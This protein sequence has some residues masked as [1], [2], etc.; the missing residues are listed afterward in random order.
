MFRLNHVL[1]SALIA[2]FAVCTGAAHAV[3]PLYTERVV[4]DEGNVYLTGSV[5]TE[6][7]SAGL[8]YT[9]VSVGSG[10]FNYQISL[11]YPG[12]GTF[13]RY[14]LFNPLTNEKGSSFPSSFRRVTSE[15]Q[16]RRY[17]YA[18][19]Q[20]GGGK[21]DW[22]IPGS[23]YNLEAQALA[24]G[25][26]DRWP[27]GTVAKPLWQ[28]CLVE[29][30]CT[31][32]FVGGSG[33][34][35]WMDEQVIVDEGTLVPNGFSRAG[36]TFAGW[37]GSNAR[38]YGD[39]SAI[40]PLQ[41]D[42]TLTASWR[43]NTYTV[44]FD[45][46]GGS[47]PI[48]STVV[49]FDSYYGT[50]PT[51]EK[52]GYT[53]AGWY[54]AR[55]GGTR[56]T[57]NTAVKIHATHTLYARWEP[58]AHSVLLNNHG[59]V[60][61]DRSVALVYGSVQNSI[62]VPQYDDRFRFSGY[63]TAENGGG[64]CYWNAEG[65]WVAGLW[66][67]L[68]IT[69]LHA[70]RTLKS[71]S[72]DP[73]G[74]TCGTDEID[75]VYDLPLGE[76]PVPQLV[77]YAFTGWYTPDGELVSEK[78]RYDGLTAELTARWE[79]MAYEV[80]FDPGE[81]GT[82][83]LGSKTVVFDAPY[84]DLPS[85]TR[86]KH[87]HLGWETASGDSVVS[88]TVVSIPSNHVLHA[89]WQ[90]D[91][92][93]VTFD[94][95]G[96]LFVDD[97]HFTAP[98][99]SLFTVSNEYVHGEAWGR[100][101]ALVRD[102]FE[103][104]GWWTSTNAGTR[105]QQRPG[106]IADR[107]VTTLYARW[108]ENA[109]AAV[110]TVVFEADDGSGWA[111]TNTVAAGTALGA[112]PAPPAR[113]GYRFAWWYDV[114]TPESSPYPVR[115]QDVVESDMTIKARW[116]VLAL[117]EATGIRGSLAFVTD[118][119]DGWH[120]ETNA[121]YCY[122]QDGV[123]NGTIRSGT[124]TGSNL[125]YTSVMEI[126]F[127]MP[128]EIT[129]RAVAQ[130]INV[131]GLR[132]QVAMQI[133]GGNEIVLARAVSSTTQDWASASL[134]VT[135]VKECLVFDY[136]TS[137]ETDYPVTG[138]NC[139]WLSELAW[140][141][142]DS[143]DA[144]ADWKSFADTNLTFTTGGWAPWAVTTNWA[145]GACLPPNGLATVTNLPDA[146]TSWLAAVTPAESGI[147]TFR[148]KVDSEAGYWRTN[149]TYATCDYLGFWEGHERTRFIDGSMAGFETVVVTNAGRTAQTF[150]WEYVKDVS[151]AA[152]EDRAFIDSV[153]W[154]SVPEGFATIM[155]EM[156]GAKESYG[157]VVLRGGLVFAA[158][159]APTRDGHA[160]GGWFSDAACERP[161]DFARPVTA[162][163]TLYA[164]WLARR[165][166]VT[167][168]GNTASYPYDGT[169]KCVGGFTFTAAVTGG[170]GTQYV[171]TA[172]DFTFSGISNVCGTA[173]GT[174]TGGLDPSDF[175]NV[176]TADFAE[177][178][179]E[180][181]RDITLT[182][183]RP[184]V[185]GEP[186]GS[187]GGVSAYDASAVYGG[188]GV[189]VDTNALVTAY[190]ERLNDPS[191]RVSFA[192]TTNGPWTAAAPVLV[193]A[194]RTSFWYRVTSDGYLDYFHEIAVTVEPR[195]V[196]LVSG[197]GTWT[198]DGRAHTNAA[199]VVGGAGFVGSDGVTC[200]GFAAITAVGSVDNTFVYA[201]TAGTRAANYSVSL[202]Y[203]RLTVVKDT[204]TGAPGSGTV[205]EGGFSPFDTTVTYDGTAVTVDAPAVTAAFGEGAVVWFARASTGPW[206][207]EAPV[208]T[209]IGTYTVWYKAVM[210]NYEDYIG[211]IKVTVLPVSGGS[212]VGGDG[213]TGVTGD[214]PA[215][216]TASTVYDGYL[217]DDL[218]GAPCGTVQV[219]IGKVSKKTLTSKVTAT[220]YLADSTKKLSFRKGVADLSGIVTAMTTKEWTLTPVVGVDGLDGTLS[221]GERTYRLDGVRNRFSSKDKAEKA[222]VNEIL[223][224]FDP[225]VNLAWYDPAV[226][227]KAPGTGWNVMTVAFS[228]RGKVKFSVVLA[229]GTKG[230]GTGQ[231]LVGETF[232]MIPVVIAKKTPLAA[233]IFLPRDG[234]SDGI[235]VSGLTDAVIGKPGT[236][237]EGATFRIDA[238][239]VGDALGDASLT[240]YLP[241]GLS[242]R[243]TGNRF[244]VADGARAGKVV[245]NRDK[246]GIDE[247]K[248]GVNPAA[249][250]LSY[251]R[252]TGAFKGSFKAYTMV[253]D[254]PKGKTVSV[255]G[256]MIDGRCYGTAVLK[257]VASWNVE[258]E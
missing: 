118:P 163:I 1:K 143:E 30:R 120:P 232:C 222:A 192:A 242:V 228:S 99:G 117:E 128:G 108:K 176:N 9:R 247:E 54:T 231:L 170:D 195:A 37:I 152:G 25:W 137:L 244:V 251:K 49:T 76:L 214:D 15:I 241:D 80:S 201:F 154:E 91:T 209:E 133:D 246:T 11:N 53:F 5:R 252:T 79:P 149:D 19:S 151:D 42:V 28:E 257:R 138:E 3:T 180:I 22:P 114:T 109:S 10:L 157:P 70:F 71:V 16:Y 245:L 226:G 229:D 77:G 29:Y 158:P 177:V 204:W 223:D 73:N 90:N 167:V 72:L 6:D 185:S 148:W 110:C 47:V 155:F 83:A 35:G 208:F 135:N 17:L 199:V 105:V 184:A 86:P 41:Q 39:G 131:G 93:P 8:A 101:P 88:G 12:G 66:T 216:R 150:T 186:D 156:N 221:N 58:I 225:G 227:G 207:R 130:G 87:T 111:V 43:A 162:D 144:L 224:L 202:E 239:A 160:F 67:D 218:L 7:P 165:V 61:G 102:G 89:V 166:T 100:F 183:T 48:D 127:P 191:C 250:K 65:Q 56:V 173:I 238:G 115:P 147:L 169:E 75:V 116:S 171:Y 92:H 38:N 81:A 97:T 107:A 103:F 172:D 106:M 31:I 23:G 188:G 85:A 45:A 68:S 253:K 33:A 27:S 122:V 254:R 146:R 198:Y 96:G 212:E 121:A 211:R 243:Q 63:F 175:A 189:T 119:D 57:N 203:G 190:A 193:D 140:R 182:V 50:L 178:T 136:H 206:S 98:T 123:T 94:A 181:R 126:Y 104:A 194:G 213:V 113:E 84:G 129:V 46:N 196:T 234:S 21:Y 237:N 159:P 230:S 36:Y 236:L 95:M 59:A 258:I 153:E 51:P 74:G 256:V 78:T 235:S 161:Y 249:L 205:P 168:V 164:K 60:S 134:W 197:S 219:K 24:N 14:A 32:T 248:A 20:S 255:S 233:N 34:S 13:R 26:D 215:W 187:D 240:G 141:P 145:G 52:T 174:Y 124:P 200:S 142:V 40:G 44:R 64:V 18:D 112:F 210:P 2:C 4:D 179:F 62:N 69:E 125:V 55:T 220:V 82:C 217:Y 132:S 139:G